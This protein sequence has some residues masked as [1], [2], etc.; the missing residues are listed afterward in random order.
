[1]SSAPSEVK[2][3]LEEWSEAI[4]HKDIERLMTVYSLE[5]V[6]FDCV[7][8]LQIVGHEAVKRNFLRWFDMWEGP[9]GVEI[10]DQT[11]TREH[12]LA[13][14]YMMHR[15]YG[16]LTGGK[17][18]DYWLRVSVLF[19]KSSSGWRLSH[20]HVSVPIDFAKG[21]ALMDLQP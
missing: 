4:R 14:A 3:L 15:T 19:K 21:T 11:I 10:R 2:V 7:A 12:D 5:I 13:A 9:I 16:T 17:Q 18:V 20:E 1:M 6:Y 8:P